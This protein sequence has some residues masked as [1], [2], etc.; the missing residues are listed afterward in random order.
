[1]IV[2]GAETNGYDLGMAFFAFLGTVA[3]AGIGL[4]TAIQARA[5]KHSSQRTETELK[6][7]NGETSGEAIHA[8]SNTLENLETTVRGL[9][10]TGGELTAGQMRMEQEQKAMRAE[11]R[12]HAEKDDERFAALERTQSSEGQSAAQASTSMSDPGAE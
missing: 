11:H 9:V 4:Y 1:M 8:M 5:A 7:P 2:L 6:G 10:V 3:V 12:A